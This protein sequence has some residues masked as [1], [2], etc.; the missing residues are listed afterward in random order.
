VLRI[1][2]SDI[3]SIFHSYREEAL[4]LCRVRIVG[5]VVMEMF[6]AMVVLGGCQVSLFRVRGWFGEVPS[7]EDSPRPFCRVL[8]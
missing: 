7:S 2:Y 6:G 5:S 8:T 3:P 1:L 4:Y